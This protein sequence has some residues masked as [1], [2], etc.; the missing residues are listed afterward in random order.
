MKRKVDSVRKF[1]TNKEK[2]KTDTLKELK[3]K[4]EDAKKNI[5]ELSAKLEFIT[6]TREYIQT[7]NFIRDSQDYI[8]FISKKMDTY[9]DSVVSKEDYRAN[10]ELINE[11]Q[12]ALK[13]EYAPKLEKKVYELV[14]V[15]DEYFDQ[16]GEDLK[17][18]QRL[19]EVSNKKLTAPVVDSLN[20]ADMTSDKF[21]YFHEFIKAYYNHRKVV[22]DCKYDLTGKTT[23][24]SQ[25]GAAADTIKNTLR[26][27][28][29]SA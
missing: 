8:Q 15:M 28:G 23:H 12:S 3:Q 22:E 10:M 14:A 7:K 4:I 20:I 13:E 16:Y 25:Y 18:R 1:V 5:E 24:P 17:L 26:K 9:A 6:D 29:Y 19:C 2:E 21:Y 11:D 27:E